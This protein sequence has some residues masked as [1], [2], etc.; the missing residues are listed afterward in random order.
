MTDTANICSL[1]HQMREARGGG[2][3]DKGTTAGRGNL[4][5][6]VNVF[7]A[8]LLRIGSQRT[9]SKVVVS[10]EYFCPCCGN[11]ASITTL[12]RSTQFDLTAKAATRS[13]YKCSTLIIHSV[14]MFSFAEFFK[15]NDKCEQL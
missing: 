12:S 14:E 11:N 5:C 4:G 7:G 8:Y 3:D 10:E 1:G 6:L 15:Y 2:G 13:R 9:R